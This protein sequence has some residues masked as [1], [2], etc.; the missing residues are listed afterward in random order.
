MAAIQATTSWHART[1]LGRLMRLDHEE[2]D[3][4]EPEGGQ[5]GRQQILVR[6]LKK[7]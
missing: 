1:S 3:L 2:Q 6:F 7:M 5:E 4:I